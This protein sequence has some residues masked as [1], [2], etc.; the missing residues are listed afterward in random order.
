MSKLSPWRFFRREILL[1]SLILFVAIMVT[2]LSV[3]IIYHQE[4][5]WKS[6][7]FF[8]FKFTPVLA[9]LL[10]LSFWFDWK[11]FS[12]WP[13]ILK[14]IKRIQELIPESKQY[15]SFPTLAFSKWPMDK[16]YIN[17]IYKNLKNYRNDVQRNAS[18]MSTVLESIYDSIL[19]V[20]TSS[21]V[22]FAN[23]KFRKTFVAKGVK[24]KKF[25]KLKLWEITRNKEIL[26]LFAKVISEKKSVLCQSI[27]LATADSE[28]TYYFDVK[29]TPLDDSKGN[30]LGAVSIFHDVTSRKLN[31]Q[32]QEDFVAN[33][34]HEI[35]TPLTA[36]KGHIQLLQGLPKE[37]SLSTQTF[38]KKIEKNTDRLTQL[39][40]DVSQLSSILSVEEVS[41]EKIFLEE[42][43]MG[44]IS[45]MEQL[46]RTKKITVSIHCQ[47]KNVWA[48]PLLFEQ[49]ISN[50]LDNAFKYTPDGGRIKVSY[51]DTHKGWDIIKI[52]DSGIG[53]DNRQ[54][55]RI[56]ERF[57]RADPSRSHNIP[58]TGLGLSIAQRIMEKHQGKIEVESIL[59]KGTAFF[60]KF[61]IKTE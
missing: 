33:I 6:A 46:Y 4:V 12:P 31:E 18:Q 55:S 22:L 5:Q 3:Y 29:I 43:V 21:E 36:I 8:L 60:V 61:P 10:L 52:E 14:K 51:L 28:G 50:L 2:L 39:V 37:Q 58:G 16:R 7:L 9:I 54:L 34:G 48:M 49:L 20:D 32:M 44:I 57:Y 47:G 17:M 25:V 26:S 24:K 1:R 42:R 40:D 35:R 27:N 38:L 30:I 59:D 41:K 11:T 13:A 53:I 23:N 56:F 15:D 45:D 19:A